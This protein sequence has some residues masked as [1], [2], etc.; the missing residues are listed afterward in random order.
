VIPREDVHFHTNDGVRLAG[1]LYRPLRNT[2]G[3][4]IVL[5]HG[6]GCV[7]EMGLAPYAEAFCAAGY[8]CLVY[9]H[10][11]LGASE[12]EPRAELDPWQQV[13]DMRDALTFLSLQEGVDPQQL[14]L[15]GTS[16][17]GG[18]V[19]VASAMD[20]RV[21]CVV[22]VVPTLSGYR[23][24]T[25]GMSQEQIDAMVAGFAEDRMARMRGEPPRRQ[26]PTPPGSE[27]GNWLH[28]FGAG[29]AYRGDSTL[30]SKEL[31][32]GYEPVDFIGRIAPTPFLMVAVTHDERCPREEQL[33]GF[34]R[35]QEPK[36][37]VMLEGGHYSV[38]DKILAESSQAAV[39][40]FHRHLPA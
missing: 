11:N 33:A 13:S 2:P 24:S 20:R 27:T 16:Y 26:K 8:T 35:A 30:R 1:W 32:M 10:R 14:G 9:D 4:A 37:M 15:W 23:S 21:R 40:W 18:H 29:T 17:A 6:T 31:R 22:A 12:G 7:K 39:A 3:P 5:T 28:A 19:I 34:E 38:Y 25:I 36:H